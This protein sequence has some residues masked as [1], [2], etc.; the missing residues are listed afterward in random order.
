MNDFDEFWGLVE[1]GIPTFTLM[2]I[3][4]E[5]DAALRRYGYEV[6]CPNGNR[7][8]LDRRINLDWWRKRFGECR[9]GKYKVRRE[10]TDFESYQEYSLFL[11]EREQEYK[12]LDHCRDFDFIKVFD[13]KKLRA[14]G[15]HIPC[16]N[17]VPREYNE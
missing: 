10:T 1:K 14:E 9:A 5:E 6:V 4:C 7:V 13:A 15:K 8:P 11:K 12:N 2:F 3:Q 17:T 16:L